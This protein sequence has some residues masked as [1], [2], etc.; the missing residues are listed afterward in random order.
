MTQLRVFV[1]HSSQ[2]KPF[3][4]ALVH[5]LRQAGADVWY[6]EHNLG[7]GQLLD[8]IQRELRARPIFVVVLSKAAFN[9]DWVCR[10][11]KWAYSLFTQEPSRIILPVVATAIQRNDFDKMLFLEDFKRVEG[12]ANR[13]YPLAEAV[14]RTLRLLGLTVESANDHL[15]RAEALVAGHHA[16]LAVPYFERALKLFER[17]TISTP[18]S[19][20]AWFKLG[21]VHGMLGDFPAAL[22]AFDHA[23]ALDPTAIEAW[24]NKGAILAS[25]NRY[26]DAL[27]AYDQA[28]A[29][30]PKYAIALYGKGQALTNLKRYEDALAVYD[31]AL[32]LDPNSTVAWRNKAYVLSALG[33]ESEAWNARRLANRRPGRYRGFI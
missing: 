3:A 22:V 16:D 25:L 33:R 6:D 12:P 10:E 4:D 26:K 13:P 15:A 5:A 29:L 2:D 28:L 27:A 30:N 9:S 21:Y 14:D 18:N 19:Y 8:E 7:A 20:S 1:S 32:A 31:Q 17:A 11:C 23:L 24:R